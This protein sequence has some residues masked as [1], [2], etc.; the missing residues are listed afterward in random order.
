MQNKKSNRYNLN[1]S[2][3]IDM[4]NAKSMHNIKIDIN[5][6][7]FYEQE[8]V[9]DKEYFLKVEDYFDYVKPGSNTLTI[10]WN[11]EHD[12]EHKHMKI[13]KVVINKQHLAPFKVMID[14][15]END[16]IKDLKSTDQGLSSYRKQLFNPGYHHGWYGTYKFRFAIDPSSMSDRT[17]QALRSAN[18]IH[19]ERIL[20]D[21]SRAKHLNR[22][23]NS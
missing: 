10:T 3:A 19:N 4:Y 6:K 13:R 18:G 7:I 14:P 2:L 21:L 11:G 20:T 12:C 17:Q 16:Y 1:T 15:I 5:K 23:N 22:T 8:L 9:K